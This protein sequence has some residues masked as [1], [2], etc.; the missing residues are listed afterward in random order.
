MLVSLPDGDYSI[1]TSVTCHVFLGFLDSE[2]VIVPDE[3]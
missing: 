1:R 2:T 3:R